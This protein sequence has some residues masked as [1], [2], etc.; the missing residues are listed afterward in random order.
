MSDLSQRLFET[1]PNGLLESF[2]KWKNLTKF[3]F[4]SLPRSR[5]YLF[6][7][8]FP[9][10]FR[11]SEIVQIQQ[12]SVNHV[13]NNYNK[14]IRPFIPFKISVIE[15]TCIMK[16]KYI[17]GKLMAPPHNLK[18][19][20]SSITRRRFFS[21]SFGMMKFHRYFNSC[22]KILKILDPSIIMRHGHCQDWP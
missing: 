12:F 8:L 21:F 3:I 15:I 7:L 10:F 17:F 16:K 14:V 11:S 22:V 1:F 4:V 18:I 20:S 5:W 19:I 13:Y 2:L 6:I 9:F